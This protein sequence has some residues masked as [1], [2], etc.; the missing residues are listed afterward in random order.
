MRAI[1]RESALVLSVADDGP[2]LPDHVLERATE[3]FFTT[4]PDGTGMGLAIARAAFEEEGAA[5]L[6]GNDA[7]GGCL[8]EI[9]V[10]AP[11]AAKA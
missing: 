6:I 7:K 10:P 3:P 2:G 8:V 5:L 4:K 11:G 1:S 9:V